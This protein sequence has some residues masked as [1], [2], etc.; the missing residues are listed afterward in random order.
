VNELQETGTFHFGKGR[1]T[2]ILRVWSEA[3]EIEGAVPIW[4]GVI[5]NVITGE[6]QYFQDL[7]EISRFVAPYLKEMG[8]ELK[9]GGLR[10]CLGRL[11][12]F[13]N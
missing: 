6:R 7:E 5:E 12:N 2:F 8:V 1:H 9:K 10:R 3:R 11:G 4:R 13:K